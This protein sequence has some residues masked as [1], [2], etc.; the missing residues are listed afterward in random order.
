MTTTTSAPFAAAR[1]LRCA[2]RRRP[3][4]RSVVVVELERRRAR[5][6]ARGLRTTRAGDRDDGRGEVEEP[7][8]RD[9]GRGGAV[10]LGDLRQ[11]GAA[12]EPAGAT[13]PAERRVGD[14]GDSGLGAALDDSATKGA[15]VEDAER[16]L[17]RRDRGELERLVQLAA[18]DVREPDPPH[19][20]FVDEP[21]ERAHR[22]PPRRSRVGHMDEVEVDREAVERF[23]ARLAV[24]ANRLRA[25][26]RDPPAARAG[27]AS[28]GHD[29][30]VAS[31]PASR[32]ARASS[33]SFVAVRAGGVEHGDAG[34]GG[35]RDRR[36]RAF[37]VTILVRRQPHAAEADAELRVREPGQDAQAS[38]FLRSEATFRSAR[39]RLRSA[40]RAAP[41]A[42]RSSASAAASSWRS[43]RSRSRR[44]SS[45]RSA[46]LLAAVASS[47]VPASAPCRRRARSRRPRSPRPALP[48]AAP[49]ARR[50]RPPR[51]A[52]DR[53]RGGASPRSGAFP[54]RRACPRPPRAGRASA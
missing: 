32:S 50:R 34:L 48:G 36:E 41:S 10:G 31:A 29:R 38:S 27:H 9:L 18:V 5:R 51:C 44:C 14:H 20:T 2:G 16:D 53:A 12:R 39:A 11:L 7:G 52:G 37:L 15:I 19:E 30:A 42:S 17:H 26:V 45:R 1:R 49:R 28:L 6:G 23:E 8:E 35:R 3:E 54:T 25:P 13:R 24:G 43:S 40:S 47:L 21:R 4:G 22:G 33:A 46:A